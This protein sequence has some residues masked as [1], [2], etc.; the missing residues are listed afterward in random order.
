MVIRIPKPQ[1]REK[2]HFMTLTRFTWAKIIS[3]I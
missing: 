3:T 2:F 1:G